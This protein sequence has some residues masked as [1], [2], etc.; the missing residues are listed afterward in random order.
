M[1]QI[2][3]T[4]TLC[5]LFALVIGSASAARAQ[6]IPQ[7]RLPTVELKAGMHKIVAEVAR[8]P[9]QRSTG[10]MMRARMAP[11]EAML[12]V[13]DAASEQ[14][15]WMRNTLLPLSIAFI[16]DDGTVINLAD[17]KPRDDGSHCSAKPV[18]YALEMNQGWF[19]SRNIKPGFRLSGAPF[20]AAVTADK[21]P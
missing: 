8:T 2:K 20:S 15:F 7:P 14:C 3:P 17:M 5:A 1:T 11:H 16:A 9:Q 21:K 18:R 10:M 19:A 13:F 4:P 12:F 6:D